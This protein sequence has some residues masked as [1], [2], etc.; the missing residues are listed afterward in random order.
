MD[1][2]TSDLMDA[3]TRLSRRLR[4]VFDQQVTAH[5]L[6]YPRARALLR[7]AQ[8]QNITQ[9]ELANEL[10]VEQATMGRLLD[11]MEENHLVERRSDP[12]DRR[13]KLLVLTPRGEEQA[14][15]VR[16]IA[17]RMRAQVFQKIPQKE[18]HVA[19]ALFKRLSANLAKLEDLDVVA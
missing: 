12:Q 5:G 3:V 18:V 8:K 4:T 9:T 10:N 6:T 11:R 14:A 13:V 1:P 2:L 19:L 17:D 7:L 16:S 15:L